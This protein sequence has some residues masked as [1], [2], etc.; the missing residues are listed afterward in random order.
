MSNT[1]D[2]EY[3]RTLGELCLGTDWLLTGERLAVI[4]PNGVRCDLYDNQIAFIRA[5]TPEVVLEL[6]GAAECA[7]GIPTEQQSIDVKPWQERMG[8]DYI[9]GGADLPDEGYKVRKLYEHPQAHVAPPADWDKLPYAKHPP[10]SAPCPPTRGTGS[11]RHAEPAPSF[12]VIVDA[13]RDPEFVTTMR[14]AAQEHINDACETGVE[15]AG[16]WK[17]LP[18]FEMRPT[19]DRLWDQTIRDRDTYHEWADK[20]AEAIAKHFGAYIGEHS[21]MNCPWAEALEAIETAEPARAPVSQHG[22]GDAALADM[23]ARKDAAYYERNQVVAALAKCF[24]SGVA[25]TAIEGWSEDWHG[26]V[27]IDLPS[28]Q[29]SWHF[30]DSHAHLFADL[31]SYAGTWDGH[32]T[33][34]KYRRLAT[35]PPGTGGEH[36]PNHNFALAQSDTAAPGEQSE[37]TQDANDLLSQ[38]SEEDRA[39]AE[40]FRTELKSMPLDEVAAMVRGPVILTALRDAGAAERDWLEDFQHENGMY[41]SK[42]SGCG[43]T[44]MG[45]KRR[46]LCKVCDV[47][48]D[49][50]EGGS[51]G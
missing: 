33:P 21:N 49:T 44:F 16:K 13:D 39:E 23:E 34:E 26:C 9:D 22:A 46:I 41:L 43:H 30:H 40:K 45:Y 20:L 31:P 1:V 4:S 36:A 14:H 51:H 50:P 38:L 37:G 2:K 35:L 18:V 12:F 11:Q 42:C 29:A 32:D 8:P 15:G 19:D 6:L 27:Y 10:I 25:R 48:V 3:L 28:G 47:Q 24:P 5:T 17:A 7:A